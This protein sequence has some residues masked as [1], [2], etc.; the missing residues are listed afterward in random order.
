MGPIPAGSAACKKWTRTGPYPPSP[1]ACPPWCTKSEKT[2]ARPNMYSHITVGQNREFSPRSATAS[3]LVHW[4][5]DSPARAD[6]AD[7]GELEDIRLGG[8]TSVGHSARG[9]RGPAGSASR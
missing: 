1:S 6:T 8:R 3:M 4:S 7:W 2:Y 5:G 9:W